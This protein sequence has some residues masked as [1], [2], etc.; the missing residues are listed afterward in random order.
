MKS[1]EPESGNHDDPV[2]P[3][4]ADDVSGDLSSDLADDEDDWGEFDPEAMD[5]SAWDST[6]LEDDEDL[7][8]QPEDG[9]FW[10]DQDDD[11]DV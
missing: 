7:E 5:D 2:H 9:D 10:L 8:S 4:A 3:T 6:G 1:F 11:W